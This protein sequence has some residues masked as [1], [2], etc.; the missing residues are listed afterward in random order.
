MSKI[1]KQTYPEA[2]GNKNFFQIIR[3]TP[4]TQLYSGAGISLLRNI[5]GSIFLFGISAQ[6][7]KWMNVTKEKAT[8]LQHFI[9]SAAG[10]SVSIIGTL[11]LDVIKTRLQLASN[12]QNTEKKSAWQQGIDILK[13]EG[14][15]AFLKASG[16]KTVTGILKAALGLT[17]FKEIEHFI[18]DA[19]NTTPDSNLS[20]K[21][22]K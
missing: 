2:F 8:K 4:F 3:T 19:M 10:A 7:Y 1:I 15:S 16:T 5:P 22:P 6:T 14:P 17:L 9:A 13:K 21:R 12:N 20:N 11:P 18:N